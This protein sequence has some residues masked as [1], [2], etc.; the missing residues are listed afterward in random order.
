M[1]I[2]IKD[3]KKYFP[4]EQGAFKIVTGYKKALDGISFTLDSGRIMGVVG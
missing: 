1:I 3:L 4:I 2:E